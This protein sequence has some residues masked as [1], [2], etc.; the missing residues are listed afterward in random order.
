[1]GLLTPKEIADELLNNAFLT[2]DQ[3]N[4]IAAEIYQPLKESLEDTQKAVVR[5]AICLESQFG[6]ETVKAIISE[7]DA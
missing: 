2:E 3:A 1:M 7:L 5:L 4:T 6:A